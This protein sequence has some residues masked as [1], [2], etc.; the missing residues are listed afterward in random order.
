M[1]EWKIGV[2]RVVVLAG[3]LTAGIGASAAF[4]NPG[5]GNGPPS[6]PPGQGACEHGN[7]G[8]ACKPDPQP[9]HGKDCDEHGQQGGVN[10]DHCLSTTDE[11][12]TDET[13]TS[14]TTTDE[15]T[16]DETTTNQTTTEDTTSSATTTT[17]SPGTN[18]GGGTPSG[19]APSTTAAA[20][21]V[22]TVSP[23][24]TRA[25]LHRALARQAAQ[26]ASASAGEAT[27]QPGELPFTG[28]PAWIL[29]LI[30]SLM[31]ATGF[32]FRRIPARTTGECS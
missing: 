28:F 14:E 7:S 1:R 11:T 31:L 18:N 19:G 6:S 15:T 16:T 3:L 12:T 25:Q 29:V 13:T 24:L 4:A 5:N 27:G 30:G 10:E 20:P 2:A 23:P 21:V 26:V 22:K 17:Q 8:Q 32:A 9:T